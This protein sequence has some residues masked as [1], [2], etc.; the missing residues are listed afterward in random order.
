[1]KLSSLKIHNY[2]GI[3]DQEIALKNYSLLVGPNNAGKSSV[4]DAIRAFYEKDGFKFKR[5]NDFP[6]ISTSDQESWIELTFS[7][8]NPEYESLPDDYKATPNRLCVRKYFATEQKMG[9]GKPSTGYIFAYK[10][11]GSPANTPFHGAKNVQS[12]KFGDLVYIPAISKVD[13]HAKLSGPSALRDLLTDIMTD[14]VEGGDAYRDFTASVEAF[15]ESIVSEK[16]GDNRSLAGFESE[17]NLLLQPWDTE[18][19]LKFPTPSAAEIIKS[20]LDW[21]LVDQAVGQPQSIDS[22]GSGFQ[23]HFI[24]SL[25]QLGARYIAKKEE[26]KTKEFAPSMTL[27]L[28]EEPEAFLHPPQQEVLARSLRTLASTDQWQVVCATH[29]PQFVSKST[30]DIPAIVRLRRTQGKVEV[31]QI[32]AQAWTSIVDA[33]QAVQLNPARYPKL[34]RKIHEDDAKPEMEA[35]KH[36]LWLN[37]DRSSIFFANHVLLVEGP[38]EV[39]LIAR[40]VGGSRISNADCGLHVLDCFGKYNIHRFMNLLTHLGVSHAVLYDD[41]RDRE[42]HA[43]FSQLIHETADA[44]LTQRIEAIP[45]ELE[46]FLGIPK[47][48]R[49]DRKP[50]HVLYLYETGQIDS[51]KLDAFC[52]L[53]SSCLPPKAS[54]PSNA[55][56]GV[57]APG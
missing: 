34:A 40:L 38:T 36:F 55:A 48:G 47:A 22:Y 11:D 1:M 20:M 21:D 12:G 43:E 7:L 5:E 13:E 19:A 15:S 24:Y 8:T 33:N 25:I 16:T 31:F 30:D 23:R 18:F 51:A 17:L 39:A 50:Q 28:F 57:A 45:G 2:R 52:S 6:L 49:P 14:V 53:V 42:E 37:P 32:D 41:D 54:S 9:D 26:K 46:D 27:V 56:E 3:L 29:S 10:T 4:I 35:V 44:A